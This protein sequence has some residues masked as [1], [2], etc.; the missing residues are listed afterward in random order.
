MAIVVDASV[1]IKW[2]LPEPGREHAVSLLSAFESG[3][4]DLIAPPL[5]MEEVASA[6]SKRCR[7]KALTGRQ[8]EQAFRNFETRRPILV[9]D[10]KLVPLG[11]SLSV[12]HQLSL[13]DCL[14]L[15]LAIDQRA[16]LITADQRFHR[17]AVRH[18]PFTKLLGRDLI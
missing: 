1:A 12:Q 13:W 14:Y 16:D 18:Y 3:T 17:A 10:R 11:L 9:E 6:L 2:V 5:I 4:V 8:A 7:R 15:A